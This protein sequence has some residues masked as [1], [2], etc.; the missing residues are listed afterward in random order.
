MPWKGN[1]IFRFSQGVT[2]HLYKTYLRITTAPSPSEQNLLG[3][4]FHGNLAVL[5]L[6]LDTDSLA[7]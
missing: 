6:D 2:E 1:G 5:F 4:P 7:P 3:Q